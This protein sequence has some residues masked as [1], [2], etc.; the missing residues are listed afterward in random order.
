MATLFKNKSWHWHPTLYLTCT[1]SATRAD[2]KTAKVRY[3]FDFTNT[4][5]SGAYYGSSNALGISVTVDGGTDTVY[6]IGNNYGSRSGHLEFDRTNTDTSGSSDISIYVWCH[7]GTYANPTGTSNNCTASSGSG[8]TDIGELRSCPYHGTWT[9]TVYYPKYNPYTASSIWLNPDD[10]TKIGRVDSSS[11]SVHYSYNSGSNS[12][13]PISL[14]IH[15]YGATSWGVRWEPVIRYVTGSSNGVWDS[16]NLSSAQG[17]ANGSRYRITLVSNRGEA[18]SPNSWNPQDGYVIYTYQEP[19]INTGLTI[20]RTSQNANQDNKFTIYGTNNRAWSSYENEFQ[21]HYRIKRGSDN[22]TSWSNLGNI[23]SWSPTPA[24]IRSLVSK[25]YDGQTITLQMKRYSPSSSWYSNN[26]ASN[27]FVVYYR[28]RIGISDAI[29]RKNDSTGSTIAKDNYVKDDSSLSHIYLSWNYDTSNAQAGYTQG[30]RIRLY[31]AAGSIVKT[32]FTTS[33]N[34]KIP[35]VDIPRVQQTYIDI[36]PYY[37]NDTTNTSNYWYYKGTINKI[38]FVKIVGELETPAITYP[39][40]NSDWINKDFRICFTLPVDPDYGSQNET[41][42]YDNIEIQLNGNFTIRMKDTNGITTS[43]T[44]ILNTNCFNTGLSG[45]TYKRNIVIQPSLIS[46][47]PISNSYI[48]KVRVRKKYGILSDKNNW[49]NWSNPITIKVNNIIIPNY[50]NQYILASHYN[51]I[52]TTLNRMRNT[53]SV[54]W[55]NIPS[56]AIPGSTIIQYNRYS[57]NNVLYVLTD[58]KNKVNNF[59]SFDNNIKFD[60][61]NLLPTSFYVTDEEIIT[62]EEIEDNGKNYLI[63]I[64]NRCNLL[65]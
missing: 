51:Y 36:T 42:L 59:A 26:T 64:L 50:N 28:P 38:N 27:T 2:E 29:Y 5:G 32:Y 17:F 62:D 10:Y 43:G 30:Y 23:T 31:N 60:K 65:K 39:I 14:A 15:D 11:W 63:T 34:I 8:Y 1:Y 18:L 47:F 55:N 53:Y 16:V 48:I 3:S 57:Y 56:D 41:Y 20:N 22:Y 21:T 7:Q 45:L 19:R 25:S 13:C 44:T 9:G 35:K 46:E 54:S 12:N 37:S 6:L 4:P 49:S 52:K 58:I 61:N 24:D 40:N 33:K